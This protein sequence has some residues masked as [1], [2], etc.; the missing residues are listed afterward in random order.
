MGENTTQKS[1]TIMFWAVLL[2]A[3]LLVIIAVQVIMRVN[4]NTQINQLQT[5]VAQVQT[6]KEQE[7]FNA[8]F[9]QSIEFIE[10]FARRELGLVNRGEIVR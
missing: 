1:S 4:R 7:Y 2:A 10:Q 3:T 9:F 6:L 8:E 5:Q